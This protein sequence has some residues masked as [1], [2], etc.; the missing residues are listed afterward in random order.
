MV[1]SRWGMVCSFPC[2]GTLPV[3][4]ESLASLTIGG[5]VISSGPWLDSLCSVLMG[6]ESKQLCLL[7]KLFISLFLSLFLHLQFVSCLPSRSARVCSYK[8]K[9]FCSP[10]VRIHV[11]LLIGCINCV[12]LKHICW[13]KK[14]GKRTNSQLGGQLSFKIEGTSPLPVRSFVV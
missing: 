10:L 2:L 4:G 1:L 6:A 3:A 7:A 13:G 12:W 9:P 11:T 5:E 8:S 14:R